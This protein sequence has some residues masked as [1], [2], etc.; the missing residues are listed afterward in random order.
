MKTF[1]VIFF[2]FIIT[3][4]VSENKTNPAYRGLIQS[5][6]ITNTFC[7]VTR[8]YLLDKDKEN[9]KHLFVEVY[10][11]SSKGDV[12]V[13]AYAEMILQLN[14]ILG[15][16]NK[17]SYWGFD[18]KTLTA[19]VVIR[20]LGQCNIVDS[21]WSKEEEKYMKILYVKSNKFTGYGTRPAYDGELFLEYKGKI[22]LSLYSCQTIYDLR[23]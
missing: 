10:M 23:I 14:L 8:A 16:H 22:I 2:T 9:L 1:F 7:N 15:Y 20:I 12:L 17:K 21:G 4:A 13:N 18:N 6:Y 19:D 5:K 3:T 11:K